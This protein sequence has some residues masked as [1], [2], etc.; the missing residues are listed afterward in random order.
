MRTLPLG[1]ARAEASIRGN[2]VGSVPPPAWCHATRTRLMSVQLREP[3]T[4]RAFLIARAATDVEGPR[5]GAGSPCSGTS[6]DV[7]RGAT[8]GAAWAAIGAA[9]G[10]GGSGGG[11]H[12]LTGAMPCR[13]TRP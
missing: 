1:T 12:G 10:T 11:V 6:G 7:G 8:P 5:L 13:G 2:V 9:V 4:V 3:T